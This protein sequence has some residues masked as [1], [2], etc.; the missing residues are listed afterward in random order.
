MCECARVLPLDVPLYMC[1]CLCVC[2]SGGRSVGHHRG[3]SSGPVK[4][5]IGLRSHH[6]FVAV[7]GG[8]IGEG[9]AGPAGN[10][11]DVGCNAYDLVLSLKFKL[12]FLSISFLFFF[13]FVSQ[14][15]LFTSFFFLSLVIIR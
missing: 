9:S 14:C 12:F 5:E 11:N 10:D 2:A 13:I 3:V 8:S 1:S 6:Y 15:C 4:S 7:S